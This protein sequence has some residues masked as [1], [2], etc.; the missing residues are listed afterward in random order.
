MLHGVRAVVD[1]EVV[2]GVQAQD[3]MPGCKVGRIMSPNE[4]KI[5]KRTLD[6]MQA[7]G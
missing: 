2:H 1:G 6:K 4:E 5:A 3:G 7:K